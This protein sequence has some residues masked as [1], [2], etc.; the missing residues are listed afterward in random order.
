MHKNQLDKIRI[1]AALVVIFSH[2]YP[3]TGIHAPAW[4]ENRWLHW[5]VTGGVGVMVFFCISGYLVTLSW[6]REPK[7]IPFLW[8]RLL[9]LWPG[10]LGSVLCC[11][12]FFGIIFNN[13]PL[14]QY[15]Q[16]TTTWRFF[17]TNLTLIREFPFI[18][19]SFANNPNPF[20]MNGVYWTIAMEFACYLVLAALG[21]IGVLRRSSLIKFLLLS[22]IVGFLCFAN[23]DFTGHIQHWIEYPAFFA[24]GSLI[25]MH[26]NWFQKHSKILLTTITPVLIAIYFLTPYTATAR[27]LLLPILVIHLGNLPAKDGWF[28]RLGD[29]SYGIYLYGYP[30]AQSVIA[31]WPEMN[32]WASLFLTFALSIFAGYAS[33]LLLESRALRWKNMDKN[34]LKQACKKIAYLLYARIFPILACFISLLFIAHRLP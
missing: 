32:F 26:R 4:L 34:A 33:W 5:S 2:H 11:T 7:F 28:T 29:P 22:Y 10:M 24:A 12:L 31:L 25:A 16:N 23:A 30:I 13:L 17:L 18:P 27:F 3:L 14:G 21:L 9:R 8:K 6:Y 15:L 19:G 20:V 1:L